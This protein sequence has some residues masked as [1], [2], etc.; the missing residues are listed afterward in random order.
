MKTWWFAATVIVIVIVM[1]RGTFFRGSR[2]T[3]A[4]MGIMDIITI[5]SITHKC[6]SKVILTTRWKHTI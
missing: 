3:I 4:V 1:A 6:Q 5:H 2:K